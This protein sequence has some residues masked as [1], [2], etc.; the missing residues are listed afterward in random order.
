MKKILKVLLGIVLV[1]LCM[2]GIFIY[3]LKYRVHTVARSQYS[4]YTVELQS[5]GEPLFFGDTPGRIVF[6]KFNYTNKKVDISISDDGQS[7]G[8]KN[9]SVSWYDDHV[10]VVIKGEEQS[11]VKYS[12]SYNK[13]KITET[14]DIKD[15]EKT[16]EDMGGNDAIDMRKELKLVADYLG[17]KNINYEISAKG[18]LYAYIKV[19]EKTTRSIEF[20]PNHEHEYVYQEFHTDSNTKILGFYKIENDQVID[21]HTTSWH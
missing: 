20:S 1:I 17:L 2:Y 5:V 15:A 9:W 7:L 12:F 8:K 4:I 14:Q 6:K 21:E 16:S 13:K 11:P 10:S 3:E 19:D 18:N